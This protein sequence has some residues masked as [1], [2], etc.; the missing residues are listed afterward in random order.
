MA[1]YI[2]KNGHEANYSNIDFKAKQNE[3]FEEFVGHIL[4]KECGEEMEINGERIGWC[5]KN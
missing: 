4:C 2:C 3:D 1:K 5:V